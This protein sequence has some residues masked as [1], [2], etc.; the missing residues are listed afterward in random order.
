MSALA[1]LLALSALLLAPGCASWSFTSLRTQKFVDDNGGFTIVDYGMDD[2]PRVSEF[3]GPRGIR[4][5]FRSKLK[6]MVELPDGTDFVAYQRMSTTGNLY[7]TEDERWEYFEHGVACIVAELD[8]DAY[9][10][11]F[12]GVLCAATD[13][14]ANRKRE[15]IRS[16]S[17]PQGFGR[18]SSGPRDSTGPRTIEN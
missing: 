13:N 5:K 7:K 9:M 16:S 3:V 10:T 17:T 18:D 1:R 2:Q 14:A 6:V 8:G 12:Q 11:R 4:M 15:K